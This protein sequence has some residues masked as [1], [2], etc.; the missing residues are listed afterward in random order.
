MD[1]LGAD[2]PDRDASQHCQRQ[3]VIGFHRLSPLRI[4]AIKS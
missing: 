2:N 4:Y 3:F 1:R